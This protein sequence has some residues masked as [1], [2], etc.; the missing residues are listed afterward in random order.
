MATRGR[1]ILCGFP[2]GEVRTVRLLPQPPHRESG[3]TGAVFEDIFKM[4]DRHGLGLRIA[5]NV[6]TLYR[7]FS[8]SD[9]S[10]SPLELFGLM[11]SIAARS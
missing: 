6:H 2:M 8:G 3:K 10:A 7:E 11:A 5:V 4:R 1:S 9:E